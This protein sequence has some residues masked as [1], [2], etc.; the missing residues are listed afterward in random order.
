MKSYV[1]TIA[2]F[3]KLAKKADELGIDIITIVDSAG[4]MFSEE[5][6]KYL[7]RPKDVTDKKIGYHRHN[8]LQ[9]AVANT[10]EAIR[11]GATIVDSSLQGLGGGQ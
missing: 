6:G 2:E 3:V 1:V 8:N 5:L 4:G 10:L 7:L 11:C 9:L